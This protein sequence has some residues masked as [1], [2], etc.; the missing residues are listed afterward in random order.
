MGFEIDCLGVEPPAF[1]ARLRDLEVGHRQQGF[2]AGKKIEVFSI[3]FRV[4]VGTT[5]V[6]RGDWNRQGLEIEHT[7]AVSFTPCLL[8]RPFNYIF[9]G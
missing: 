3:A 5:R 7:N 1:A 4:E 6:F 2:R 9:D 8:H